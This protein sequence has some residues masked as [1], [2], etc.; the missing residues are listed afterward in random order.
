MNP[1]LFLQIAYL[2]NIII[3]IPVCYGLLF[4]RGVASVFSGV[5]I[6]SEGLRLMVASLWLSILIASIAGLFVPRFVAP[7]L[8]IQI[9]Y[10]SVWL[11]AFVLPLIAHGKS[12]PVGIGICFMG[13]VLTYPILFWFG[14]I[15][16]T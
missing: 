11:I 16:A 1:N 12:W 9:I 13:I 6:E 15:K 8:I 7:V 4:G 5:V 14:Y 3:L 2:A 10:K